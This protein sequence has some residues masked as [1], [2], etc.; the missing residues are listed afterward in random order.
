MVVVNNGIAINQCDL[1]FR[2]KCI[3]KF[4][5]NVLQKVTNIIAMIASVCE[6]IL[7]SYIVA[8][9]ISLPHKLQ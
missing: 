9:L 6:Y 5:S 1:G 2:C 8:K 7:T 4:V 3:D